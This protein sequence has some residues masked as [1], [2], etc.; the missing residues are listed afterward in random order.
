MQ[1]IPDRG[2]KQI[3]NFLCYFET[4]KGKRFHSVVK[5]RWRVSASGLDYNGDEKRNQWFRIF[6]LNVLFRRLL[7]GTVHVT[8]TMMTTTNVN[9]DEDACTRTIV[10]Q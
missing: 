10:N 7:S 8:K 3:A 6:Q 1:I 4:I 2:S 9:T 5:P